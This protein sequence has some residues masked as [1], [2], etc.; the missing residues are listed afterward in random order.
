MILIPAK[1]PKL[2]TKWYSDY[3][4]N[5]NTKDKVIYL[6]FDDGPT[7]EV[8]DWTL[9]V[10]DKYNAKATFFCIGENVKKFPEIFHRVLNK[11]HRIG[12]HTYNHLDGW[13][14]NFDTYIDNTQ[15]AFEV[16][17]SELKNNSKR[18]TLNAQLCFRPPF[19]KI[20]S[21]QAKALMQK[22]YQIIMWDVVTMDWMLDINK[23]RCLK[24]AIKNTVSG[25]IVVFHDS[26]KA[27]KNLEYALPKTLEYFSKRGYEFKQIPVLSQ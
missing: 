23:E 3:V 21:K 15:K 22:G 11:G 5:I 19:G 14:T 20:K 17:D 25:S 24:N 12:N 27:F 10:L 8:T 4:W 7:P 13:K 6:T 1:I 18:S 16:I 2:I 9:N 26:V